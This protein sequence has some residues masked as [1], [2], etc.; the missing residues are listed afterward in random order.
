MTIMPTS[1]NAAVTVD[2]LS[3]TGLGLS[4]YAAIQAWPAAQST[5]DPD[6][7]RP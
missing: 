1:L 4:T 6:R 5:S 2:F 3:A 7:G